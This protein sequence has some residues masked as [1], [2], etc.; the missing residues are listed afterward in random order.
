MQ[1]KIRH[2]AH[3][4][5]I[6]HV[7][8]ADLKKIPRE[9]LRNAKFY[10]DLNPR[11]IKD[12]V[13]KRLTPE[14]VINRNIELV[15]GLEDKLRIS[16]IP[17]I[18]KYMPPTTEVPKVLKQEDLFPVLR[19]KLGLSEG[20]DLL[21]KPRW[22]LKGRGIF[23]RASEQT[24][25]ARPINPV[26][27]VIDKVRKVP[28]VHV[29]PS[30]R[31]KQIIERPERFVAQ[32]VVPSNTEFRVQAYNGRLVGVYPRHTL[33]RPPTGKELKKIRELVK[34]V[35]IAY[36]KRFDVKGGRF[37]GHDIM[38]HKGKPY[39]LE[40]N[41]QEGFFWKYPK[42]PYKAMTGKTL[43]NFAVGQASL[44]GVGGAMLGKVIAEKPKKEE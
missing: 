43:Q 39:L 8:P 11:L 17:G 18:A 38:L 36:K 25:G 26:Q 6:K 24:S 28:Y 27:E 34:D 44:A 41:V 22:G 21:I 13:L 16:K 1:A 5:D 12:P 37:F 3:W 33:G 15:R 10:I 40:T 4:G 35:D 20:E 2:W 29:S 32:K 30:K 31:L 14:Q 23:L 7:S 19:K 9:E 42:N